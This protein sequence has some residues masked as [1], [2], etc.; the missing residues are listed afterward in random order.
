MTQ[1]VVIRRKIGWRTASNAVSLAM[2]AN[3]LTCRLMTKK[4]VVTTRDEG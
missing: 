4:E 3:C 2:D 1:A